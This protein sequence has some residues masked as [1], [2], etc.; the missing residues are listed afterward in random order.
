LSNIEDHP[1]FHSPFIGQMRGE[2]AN[3][4]PI[5]RGQRNYQPYMDEVGPGLDSQIPFEKL[6]QLATKYRVKPE[7]LVYPKTPLSLGKSKSALAGVGAF[8]KDK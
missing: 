6:S 5:N 7:E 4:I 1:D 8:Q 2:K 3:V